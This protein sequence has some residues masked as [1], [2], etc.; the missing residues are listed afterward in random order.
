MEKQRKFFASHVTFDTEYRISM[1]KKLRVTIGKYEEEIHKALKE[2]LGK[3][4]MEA[5]MCETGMTLSEISSQIKNLKKWSRTKYHKTGL[6]NFPAISKSIQEPYG[7][8]LIMSPWNYPFMLCMEPLAGAIAA[9]NC[10]VVK[11]SAYS[12]ATSSVIKKILAEVFP[13]EYVASTYVIPFD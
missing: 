6:A 13:D 3:D 7:G 8:V 10:C 1:L 11:P 9:G 5:Y 12:P 2:D 4:T